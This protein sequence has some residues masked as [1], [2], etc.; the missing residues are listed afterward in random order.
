MMVAQETI[1][2]DQ[3]GRTTG[4]ATAR[5]VGAVGLLCLICLALYCPGAAAARGAPYDYGA[6][7]ETDLLAGLPEEEVR[8]MR[9]EARRLYGPK[10]W[11]RIAERS[12]L[13]RYRIL[14]ILRR[15]WAPEALQLIPVVESGYNPYALS[16]AGAT[17]LWQLMPATAREWGADS[18]GGV[19]GRRS[20]V[21]SSETAVRY[22]LTMHDTFG[23]WP[24]AIAGYHMGPY[25]LARRLK[26]RAWRP[27]QGIDTLPVPR[28]TRN[29]VRLVL[30][31]VSLW[32]DGQLRFPD[33]EV[34]SEVELAPPVDIGQLA[35]WIGVEQRYI[36]EM[37]P[38]LDY[39]NYYARPVRLCLPLTCAR[40]AMAASRRFRPKMVAVRIQP[41]DTL[42][43]IA[44]RY[45]TTVARLRRL[46]PRLGRWLHAGRTLVVPAHDYR[47]AVARHNPLL[48]GR[49]R[50]HYRVRKGDTLW[51]IARRY[52]TSVRAIR[53]INRLSRDWTI[54][55]GDWLWIKAR[56]RVGRT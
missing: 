38:G 23:S 24:L 31:L 20:V 11:R 39:C 27:D 17:G 13:Y 4:M 37:N 52:G 45:G 14:R 51:R 50:I 25:G 7:N 15:H 21:T 55:P 3:D 35:R 1:I 56:H 30:G 12:R 41:G 28:A 43:S 47:N 9:A 32:R 48:N 16:H 40:R 5:G 8:A 26:H 46:N 2:R 22:L 33:P 18:R 53:R 19:N 42:W 34:T 6:V 36:F 44:R 10:R 49:H 29:Y 54:R